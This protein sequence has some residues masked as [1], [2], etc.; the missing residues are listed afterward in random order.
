M[1]C[2]FTSWA[3]PKSFLFFKENRVCIKYLIRIPHSHPLHLEEVSNSTPLFSCVPMFPVHECLIGSVWQFWR[4]VIIYNWF[5]NTLQKNTTALKLEDVYVKAHGISMVNIYTAI[6]LVV[7]RSIFLA[8]PVTVDELLR[9]HI[10]MLMHVSLTRS[11]GFTCALSYPFTHL[12]SM[13]PCSV[14]SCLAA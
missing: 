5:W 7:R 9:H 13:L 2:F 11:W 3:I 6:S 12:A 1:A 8:R 14:H 4:E 10:C